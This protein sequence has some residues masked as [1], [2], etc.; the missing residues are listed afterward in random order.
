[1]TLQPLFDTFWSWI[2][3]VAKTIVSSGRLRG[4]ASVR[5]IEEEN[6]Y[7]RLELPDGAKNAKISGAKIR[8]VDGRIPAI[9]REI[10]A[11]MQGSR[12]ELVFRSNRFLFRTLELPLRAAEFLDGIIRAQ[13]DR[14]TPWTAQEA[15][16]GWTAPTHSEADRLSLTVC[17]TPRVS[18][19]PYLAALEGLG[20]QSAFVCAA[21]ISA[22]MAA[23]IKVLEHKGQD[24]FDHDRLRRVLAGVI[25][26]IALS[27]AV[28]SALDQF[29]GA[30]FVSQRQAID[31]QISLRRT[32]LLRDGLAGKPQTQKLLEQRKR[33]MPSSVMVLE[34]L[35][36]ILPD[37]TYVTELRI[38]GEKL[39][40]IGVTHD[41][42]ALIPLMEQSHQFTH[43]TFF[44]PTTSSAGDVGE[45]F[46]IEA[47]IKPSFGAGT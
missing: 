13:I 33:E 14:L 43:A 5:L 25:L 18:F 47:R 7:F 8:I 30:D 6:N 29:V 2:E 10:A 44:A 4:V 1:M 38:E 23:P 42:P 9:S 24:A 46:H 35:S 15:A 40:I 26:L 12:A 39:Q 45:R 37:H 28:V 22:D 11:S 27:A 41:A 34:A 17:A 36:R 16:F 19:G 21:P 20:V 32:A 31:Q 3:A